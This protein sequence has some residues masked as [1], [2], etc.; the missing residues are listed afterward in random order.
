MSVRVVPVLEAHPQSEWAPFTVIAEA[1]VVFQLTGQSGLIQSTPSSETTP[2]WNIV[3][4][5][6]SARGE[7]EEPEAFLAT[8]TYVAP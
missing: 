5:R 6:R 3:E 7:N 2:L 4:K 8:S 1:Q